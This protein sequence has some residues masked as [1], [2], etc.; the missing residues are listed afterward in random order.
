MNPLLTL[1]TSMGGGFFIGIFLGYF[2]KKIIKKD[3]KNNNIVLV[4]IRNELLLCLVGMTS[5]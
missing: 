1:I 5:G 3:I 2:L 4:G